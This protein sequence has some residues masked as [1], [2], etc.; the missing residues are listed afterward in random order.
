MEW[1][2]QEGVPLRCRGWD[3]EKLLLECTWVLTE[4]HE[5]RKEV[6][7]THKI[8]KP[9]VDDLSDAIRHSFEVGPFVVDEAKD[10]LCR[11]GKVERSAELCLMITTNHHMSNQFYVD[12][13]IFGDQLSAHE[14]F[15]G[16]K[17][18]EFGSIRVNDLYN[19]DDVEGSIQ[20]D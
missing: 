3:S 12:S 15:Q 9:R 8:V 4:D 1:C 19:A 14:V 6:S 11:R 7:N 20:S 16:I 5:I 17:E 2:G 10:E 13:P 18:I